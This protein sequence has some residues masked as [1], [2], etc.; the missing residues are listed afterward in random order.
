MG[1]FNTDIL[2]QGMGLINDMTDMINQAEGQV[3]QA[4]SAMQDAQALAGKVGT[5]AG[6]LGGLVEGIGSAIGQVVNVPIGLG[7]S[8][9]DA[10]GLS[11]L[12]SP[13]QG[14]SDWFYSYNVK[15]TD[16]DGNPQDLTIEQLYNM[17]INGFNMNRALQDQLAGVAADLV[18]ANNLNDWYKEQMALLIAEIEKCEKLNKE[19]ADELLAIAKKN[20]DCSKEVGTLIGG[21]GK[22]TATLTSMIS[23]ISELQDKCEKCTTTTKR[24]ETQDIASDGNGSSSLTRK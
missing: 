3:E 1:Q 5:T 7:K 16:P 6:K 17:A 24:V 20:K 11:E 19:F 9:S 12:I 2:T 18:M 15:F 13:S 4:D 23:S 22:T 21:V 14:G 10:V 8:F